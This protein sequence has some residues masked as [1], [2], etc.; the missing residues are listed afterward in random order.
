MIPT[1]PQPAALP[2][3]ACGRRAV[4]PIDHERDCPHFESGETDNASADDRSAMHADGGIR[5]EKMTSNRVASEIV[6]TQEGDAVTAY[7]FDAESDDG[8]DYLFR[9]QA[10]GSD[11]RPF[12]T[13]DGGVYTL[14]ID[15]R[16]NTRLNVRFARTVD[17]DGKA[18]VRHPEA[19][20]E[21]LG[22][23]LAIKTFLNHD[24]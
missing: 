1:P 8:A 21:E 19:S 20:H 4:E 23:P 7:C 14:T 9:G 6:V 13:G 12:D 5:F 15:L 16:D 11:F 10:N 24:A 17:A 18:T 2:C 22:G 3:E